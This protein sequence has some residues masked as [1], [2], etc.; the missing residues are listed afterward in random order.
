VKG[1]GRGLDVCSLTGYV[2]LILH[3]GCC[4]I[5]VEFQNIVASGK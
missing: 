1:V 3:I 2:N 4:F 5:A